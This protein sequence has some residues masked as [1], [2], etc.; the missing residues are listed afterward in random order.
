M[1]NGVSTD[2]GN[3]PTHGI[4]DVR[5]AADRKQY[6]WSQLA[7]A[8][9]TNSLLAVANSYIGVPNVGPSHS[10]KEDD[11]QFSAYSGAQ[12]QDWKS[13][14][15]KD[16]MQSS[17]FGDTE[18]RNRKLPTTAMKNSS[19]EEDGDLKTEERRP[20]VICKLKRTR[21]R[22]HTL[23]GGRRPEVLCNLNH[24]THGPARFRPRTLQPEV[25][26]NLNQRTPRSTRVRPHVFQPEVVCKLNRWTL[27]IAR[28]RPH[29]LRPAWPLNDRKTDLLRCRACS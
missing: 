13:S 3:L 22:P 20:E 21:V 4:R 17:A 8:P 1:G 25:T 11:T 26:C 23:Q 2:Q 6:D 24:G 14:V 15:M 27:G 28:F 9:I 5:S 10:T 12:L 29:A 16:D 7:D 19:S 18:L